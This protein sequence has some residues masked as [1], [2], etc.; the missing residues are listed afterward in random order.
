[1]IGLRRLSYILLILCAA[2]NGPDIALDEDPAVTALRAQSSEDYAATVGV[3]QTLANRCDVFFYDVARA[4]EIDAQRAAVGTN[5]NLAGSGLPAV[6][7]ATEVALQRLLED[8]EV[9]A[10][11]GP[12]VCAIAASEVAEGTALGALLRRS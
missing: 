6:G 4:R 12:D 11:E 10:L 1:M 7:V 3:A 9:E 5:L 8:Y 2:C